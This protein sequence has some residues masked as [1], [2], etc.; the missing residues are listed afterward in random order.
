MKLNSGWTHRRAFKNR[1]RREN[2]QQTEA[3]VAMVPMKRKQPRGGRCYV[4]KRFLHS[5]MEVPWH[6][7][8]QWGWLLLLNSACWES[9]HGFFQCMN[10]VLVI[11]REPPLNKSRRKNAWGTENLFFINFQSPL[12]GKHK[13][14]VVLSGGKGGCMELSQTVGLLPPSLLQAVYGDSAVPLQAA[15]S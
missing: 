3:W 10:A 7:P 9:K 14:L 13:S 5:K 8:R 11:S 15:H 12:Y 1:E 4:A 2:G 6:S